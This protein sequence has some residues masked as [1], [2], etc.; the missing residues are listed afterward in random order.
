VWEDIQHD[1]NNV[2]IHPT[3][4]KPKPSSYNANSKLSSWAIKWMQSRVMP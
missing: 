2:L 3:T 1:R 4:S